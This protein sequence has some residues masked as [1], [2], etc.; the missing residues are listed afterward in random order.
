MQP[1]LSVAVISKLKV[2]RAV[3]VPLI[4][5]VFESRFNPVG[6]DPLVTAKVCGVVPPTADTVS[7]YET[8]IVPPGKVPGFTVIA[9]QA[10][11]TE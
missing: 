9:G 2:P 8:P 3:G 4:S 7:L 1:K 10:I 11:V 5:P 6:S